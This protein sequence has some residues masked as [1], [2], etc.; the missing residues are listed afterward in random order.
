M[1]TL[2]VV[3]KI[4]K[5]KEEST[6][7]SSD[8]QFAEFLY[9]LDRQEALTEEE[10]NSFV[11]IYRLMHQVVETDGAVIGALLNQGAEITMRNMMMA[12]R[13]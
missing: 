4:A 3:Q 9:K 13:R 8:E 2:Q 1:A 11:G 6:G 10:R 12:I 5:I 7:T